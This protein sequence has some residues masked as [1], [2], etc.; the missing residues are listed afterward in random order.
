[1]N[2][3]FPSAYTILF[4][5][6]IVVAIATWFVPAGEYDRETNEALGQEVPVPGTYHQVEQNP[7]G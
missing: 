1:M 2:L 4:G 7:Q 5:L 6:I 3:K